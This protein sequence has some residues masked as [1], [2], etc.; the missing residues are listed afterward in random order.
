MAAV[1]I[2]DMRDQLLTL[3]TV[4]ARFAAT[5]P[6]AQL[7]FPT[8]SEIDFEI[9]PGWADGQAG[10]EAPAVLITPTG[11]R[12]AMTKQAVLEVGAHC[13]IP[14][15]YQERLPASL[16]I[17]QLRYWFREGF[18][19]KEFKILS[20][21]RPSDGASEAPLPLTMAVCRGTITPFSNLQLLD[22]AVDR[23]RTAYGQ[24]TEILAD[25]KFQHDLEL[26]GFRL[27]VPEHARTITGTRVDA[28]RWCTGIDIRNSLIGLK[29]S[30]IRG[31]L[32]RYWCT[33]GCTDTLTS[34]GQFT[35]RGTFDEADFWAWAEASMDKSIASLEGSFDAVQQLTQVPVGGDV[36]TVLTDLF[37]QYNIPVRERQRVIAAMADLDGEIT[38]YD[39]QQAITQAANM[40]GLS[41]R[42]VEQLL[43]MGGHVAHAATGRCTEDHPCRRLLPDGYVPPAALAHEGVPAAIAGA[44]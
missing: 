11:A 34:T 9:Q 15:G 19:E 43:G 31:Y 4:R 22:V 33:N 20:R 17:P 1:T 40:D 41:A 12:Y 8:S 42:A 27:I 25:Y 13:G 18:G 24:D 21:E 10:D 39:I 26:T 35:R 32:F 29:P 23:L 16:L 6:L 14:R 5:E 44:N 28:D 36:V 7:T 3:D 37:G 30:D 38:M 2:D